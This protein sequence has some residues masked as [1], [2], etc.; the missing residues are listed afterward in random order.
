[1]LLTPRWLLLAVVVVILVLVFLRLSEWQLDRLAERRAAN[2]L[3]ESNKRAEPAPIGDVLKPD[4]P[5]AAS[6]E[7]RTVTVTGRYDADRELFVR[8]RHFEGEPGFHVLTPLVTDDGTALLIDR[9][10]LPQQ[11]SVNADPKVVPPP[12]GEVS[13]TG[14]VRL[15]EDVNDDQIRPE[16]GQVRF[17][18]VPVIADW[19]PYPVFGG[20]VELTKQ[21][22][23]PG[24]ELVPVPPPE[25]DEGPHL[26]YAV[27]WVIFA[28]IAVGGVGFLAYD[29]VRGGR[30]RDRLRDR[31]Y[32]RTNPPAPE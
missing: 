5:V 32:A 23:P 19:L 29:A 16:T 6:A 22:P 12:T 2:T 17:I 3:I 4:R 13:V 15:S 14:R 1:M 18:N 24:D 30:L 9:G 26:S 7:W 20:Y 21:D 31:E 10:W 25:L 28:V 8:Y 27:Q 11:G